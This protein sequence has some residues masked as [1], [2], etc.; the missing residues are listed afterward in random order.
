MD[1]QKGVTIGKIAKFAGLCQAQIQAYIVKG[2]IP[3]P[4]HSYEGVSFKRYTDSEAT[5]ILKEVKRLQAERIKKLA[6]QK[7]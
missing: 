2:D 7:K 5:V 1:F 6:K 3:T 4:T